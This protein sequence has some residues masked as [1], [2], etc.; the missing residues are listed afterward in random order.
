MAESIGASLSRARSTRTPREAVPIVLAEI[1]QGWHCV[2]CLSR[3]PRRGRHRSSARRG[4]ARG[5]GRGRG[6]DRHAHR[7][8]SRGTPLVTDHP[9]PRIAAARPIALPRSSWALRWPGYPVLAD[10]RC[11]LERRRSDFIADRS[12]RFWAPPT[13]AYEPM[14]RVSGCSASVGRLGCACVRA[15]T[16]GDHHSKRARVR[17][18]ASPRQLTRR[19]VD[20]SESA[21]ALLTARI[22]SPS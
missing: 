18:A 5:R 17:G 20:D 22:G 9:T 21:A 6:R 8:G 2:P 10:E 14:P 11:R 13:G 7:S 3:T 4:S 12:M 15:P 1:G 16:S 19:H